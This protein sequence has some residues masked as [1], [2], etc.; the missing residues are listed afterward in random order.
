LVVSQEGARQ[1]ASVSTMPTMMI[2]D[3]QGLV[4]WVAPAGATAEDA[5]AAIP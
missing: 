1:Q 5:L 2:L 3:A 4:R